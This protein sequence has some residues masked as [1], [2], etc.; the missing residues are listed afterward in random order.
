MDLELELSRRAALGEVADAW[1]PRLFDLSARAD[2][3]ALQ[4]LLADGLVLQVHDTIAAQLQDFLRARE[5]SRPTGPGEMAARVDE[6]L[7]GAAMSEYGRWVYY[8]WTL[9][10]VHVLPEA[11]FHRLRTDRNRYKI[12]PEEQE[13]L[14]AA[15]IGVVGLSVGQSVALTLALEGVGGSFRLADFDALGLSNLNRLRAG[16]HDLGVN[17]AVLAARQMFELDPYLDIQLFPHGISDDN[18]EA[19]FTAG[20]RL[21]LLIEECDDLYFKVLLREEARRLRVPVLMDTSDRGMMDVERFDRE[22]DRPPFHGLAG[23]L[24][25]SELKGLPT[26][27]KVPFVLNILDASRLSVQ[28]RAS[29][30]EIN[31]TI[32]TWPQLGSAVTLGGAL[33]TDVARRVL[34]GQLTRSGR[35][36]VDLEEIVRDGGGVSLPEYR[37]ADEGAAS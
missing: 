34:L 12:T 23:P 10:L 2:R 13:R 16:V 15:R 33:T 25:T 27:E 11:E 3:E 20:G 6:F 30:I 36:Y 8:P 26:R 35:F 5:P 24:R 32:E 17:K 9:R 22:P 4:R 7:G 31:E 28:M 18:L 14:R 21:D 37:P 19:F 1:R 29:L